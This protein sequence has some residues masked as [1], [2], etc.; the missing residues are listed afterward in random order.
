MITSGG[1]QPNVVPP[2]ASVWY[3]F[4]ETDYAHIKELWELG[5]TMAKAASMMTSTTVESR[6]LGSAWPQ[7]G[8]RPIAEAMHRNIAE[9]GMPAWSE[10]DQQFA[11][12]FQRARGVEER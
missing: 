3:Y 2:F 10:A 12:A 4:R 5:D 9:V 1:D 11:K 6:V 8:N 7:H